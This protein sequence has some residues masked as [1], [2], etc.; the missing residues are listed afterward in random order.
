[1]YVPGTN[2]S[3]TLTGTEQND[4]FRGRGGN[5]II[6]GLG[7]N[8]TIY[9]DNEVRGEIG[10]DRMYGGEGD[11]V[12]YGGDG[13]NIYDGGPG[14][15]L[16]STFIL[17]PSGYTGSTVS[18]NIFYVDDIGDRIF[19]ERDSGYD[20]VFSSISFS[21]SGIFVEE[22]TLTGNGNINATGNKFSNMLTGNSGNNIINSANGLYFSDPFIPIPSGETGAD[23][24]NGLAGD[25]TYYVHTTSDRVIESDFYGGHDKIFSDVNYSLQGQYVEDLTL[26]GDGG[27]NGY[28]PG[29]T[30]G[31]L[32]GTGNKFNNIL[33]GES[34]SNILEGLAGDDILVGG[35]S[36]RFDDAIHDFR[37]IIDWASYASAP[38]AVTVS[39]AIA[40]IAQ[41]TGSAGWDTL[42]EMEGLIGSAFNDTLTGDG[43]DNALDGRGGADRMSG[44]AGN[45]SY[46]IDNAGDLMLGETADTGA[47]DQVFASIDFTLAGRFIERLTLT[48][49]DA[50]DGT[51]NKLDNILTGN[52][53]ANALSSGPGKDTIKGGAGED[54][55]SGGDGN[56]LLYGGA[57]AD[58]LSGGDG[59]DTVDGGTGA[60]ILDGGLGDDRYYV[61]DSGDRIVG[62]LS[63]GGHDTVYAS[64]DFTMSGYVEDLV[65]GGTAVIG[66]GNRLSNVINGNAVSNTLAGGGNADRFV[67]DDPLNA[68][69]N[70][71]RITD[72]TPSFDRIMLAGSA[73]AALDPGALSAAAFK[74]LSQLPVDSTDRILY[75]PGTGSLFYDQDGSGSAYQAI[76]FARFNEGLQLSATDFF[77]G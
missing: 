69:T 51:G 26:I 12:L 63:Y 71:D 42:I 46:H 52:D 5:D 57:H 66:N 39:L 18:N 14:A 61:D 62:E 4:S 21:L 16:M 32:L 30:A 54:I 2:E 38:G 9:G 73:F 33:T 60:D 29:G 10:N 74:N 56:D 24:M 40:E 76:L 6:Y 19:V 48:G 59:N 8:D 77:H 65:M 22:L 44:G 72:F 13:D 37:E 47:D 15:D 43:S 50:I 41:N 25:D 17:S 36:E 49:T 23:I 11:D 64:V 1:M 27:F 34:A 7:G 53:A 20:R 28:R 55:L 70:V 31:V 45:D 75:D 35:E 68:A 3:E 58:T 67:F